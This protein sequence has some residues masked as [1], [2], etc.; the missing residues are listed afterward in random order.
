M[1]KYVVMFCLCLMLSG[2][3]GKELDC[4]KNSVYW[5][6]VYVT[7]TYE[8][9]FSGE[10]IKNVHFE[11]EFKVSGVLLS[12]MEDI[13]RSYSAE[14][15]RI[16]SSNTKVKSKI[17]EDEIDIEVDSKYSKLTSKEKESFS[18]INSKANYEELKRDLEQKG[19]TCE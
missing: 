10:Q 19:Y 12:D 6:N 5:D 1:K 2:C 16:K 8:V 11:K 7:D 3:G 17:D 13:R 15:E 14:F 4:E 9:K 18:E